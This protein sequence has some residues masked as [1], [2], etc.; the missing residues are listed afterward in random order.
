LLDQKDPLSGGIE[1]I[2][3]ASAGFLAAADKATTTFQPILTTTKQAMEIGVDKVGPMPDAVGLL[4][5]YKPG[6]KALVVAARVSGDAKSAFPEPPKPAEAAKA[7]DAK[8]EAPKADASKAAPAAPA[9]RA[10]GKVNVLIVADTD[11]LQ[12]QFWVDVREFLGQQVAIPNASNAA[13]V[14]GAL[15]NMSGS[16]ALLSLRG[17]GVTDRPFEKVAAIRRDAEQ[18]F[19]DKEEAL[20]NRLKEVQGELAKLEKAGDGGVLV[21]DRDRANIDKFRTELLNTRRDLRDVKLA[22]RHDIDR[23]DARLRFLNIIGVPLLIGAGALGFA[24]W[25]RRRAT[26]L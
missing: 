3:M 12:D 8:P 1:R 19:R 2:N 21:T 10:T 11:L 4:R 17:R 9:H 18:R 26:P 6:G 14:V 22:L 16:D 7:S 15:E 20:T 25:R 24:Y 23:L 13:F 5:G